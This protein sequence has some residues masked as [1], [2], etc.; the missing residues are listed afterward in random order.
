[1]DENLICE[2]GIFV[3]HVAPRW[4]L[5]G[6]N[7]VLLGDAAHATSPVGGQ[8]GGLFHSQKNS[9]IVGN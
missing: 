2:R 4:S 9:R 6:Y 7:V 8:G 5:P 3:H 1:M